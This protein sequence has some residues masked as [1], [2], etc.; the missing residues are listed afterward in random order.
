MKGRPAP[1]GCFH[2]K[3]RTY[4]TLEESGEV[5]QHTARQRDAPQQGPGLTPL[6][7]SKAP[8]GA[9]HWLDP[10]GSRG[11]QVPPA[12]APSSSVPAGRRGPRVG[13]GPRGANAR[14]PASRG[15]VADEPP[16]LRV[17]FLLPA[18][19]R[20]PSSG[21]PSL[22]SVSL[23]RANI[24]L[25]RPLWLCSV[26]ILTRSPSHPAQLVYRRLPSKWWA[27]LLAQTVRSLPAMQ[28][29]RFQLLTWEAPLEK[30]KAAHSSVL[31]WRIP[32]TEEPGGPQSMGPRR[33]RHD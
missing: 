9:P 4:R 5:S 13:G 10:T 16:S 15:G 22:G 12:W 3:A 33:V 7:P 21:V 31:A 23:P 29:T 26:V 6:P 8:P 25:N 32:W 14:N 28:E 27:S 24:T 19:S 17:A 18:V 11:Q 1:E 20:Q 30:E 2:L